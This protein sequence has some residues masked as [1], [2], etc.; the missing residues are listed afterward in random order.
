MDA[1]QSLLKSILLCA[2]LSLKIKAFLAQ[3]VKHCIEATAHKLDT[4]LNEV[5]LLGGENVWV[6]LVFLLAVFF[7]VFLFEIVLDL[8]A[9]I[10]T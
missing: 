5:V 3:D 2:K 7:L 9:V 4:R 1:S 6:I 10:S 8:N